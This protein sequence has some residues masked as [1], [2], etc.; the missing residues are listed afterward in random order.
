MLRSLRALNGTLK[1]GTKVYDPITAHGA[2]SG[3]Y[4]TL[5]FGG[6]GLGELGVSLGDLHV[7]FSKRH[8]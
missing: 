1:V 5:I 8:Y 2:I 4:L 7:E 3:Y 6:N